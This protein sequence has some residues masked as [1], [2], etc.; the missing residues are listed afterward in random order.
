M[1]KVLGLVAGHQR[2]GWAV[3]ARSEAEAGAWVPSAAS[4]GP[5]TSNGS[6]RTRTLVEL[7]GTLI[8]NADPVA[9]VTQ[10]DV[11]RERKADHAW[12][13]SA[14]DVV[15]YYHDLP[16]L[17][18]RWG[19]VKRTMGLPGNAS[20]DELVTATGEKFRVFCGE[21][22]P[23]RRR[24]AHHA[25]AVAYAGRRSREFKMHCVGNLPKCLS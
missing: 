2:C 11:P 6:E 9:L 24:V 5:Y 25:V 15:A 20:A 8:D 17:S 16:L 10:A 7:L 22:Y 12:L 21:R 14:I 18:C 23:S 4:P 19:D 1:V 13:R 3:L